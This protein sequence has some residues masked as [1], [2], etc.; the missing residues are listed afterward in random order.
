[1]PTLPGFLPL[2][3]IIYIDAGPE[4]SHGRKKVFVISLYLHT[5]CLLY[6]KIEAKQLYEGRSSI[7]LL[8]DSFESNR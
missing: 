2:L 5:L 8:S 3:P 1:M 7:P 4:E 6:E